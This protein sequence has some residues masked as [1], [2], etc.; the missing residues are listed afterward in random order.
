MPE[1]DLDVDRRRQYMEQLNIFD[2]VSSGAYMLELEAAEN[3]VKY[4]E[5]E[6]LLNVQIP[7]KYEDQISDPDGNRMIILNIYVENFKS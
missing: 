1:V 7:P 4:D 6:D 2:D 5:K 3:G